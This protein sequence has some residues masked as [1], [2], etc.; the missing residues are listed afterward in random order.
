MT[1]S[2]KNYTIKTDENN[3]EFVKYNIEVKVEDKVSIVKKTY[4]DFKN[5]NES[6]KKIYP[7]SF[8]PD[9][10]C[11]EL[12][13]FSSSQIS[14]ESKIQNLNDYLKKICCVDF[15]DENT[16]KFFNI[17]GAVRD[18]LLR[19]HKNLIE[20]ESIL[21]VSEC[22]QSD[23]VNLSVINFDCNQ[24]S[25][26]NSIRNSDRFCENYVSL[27]ISANINPNNKVEYK[28]KSKTILGKNEVTKTFK[29]FVELHKELKKTLNSDILPSF[30][31]KSFLSQPSQID[32]AGIEKRRKK[33]ERYLAHIFNDPAYHN[34]KNFSWLGIQE[35]FRL[36]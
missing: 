35:N 13:N 22:S 2:I 12:P 3:K 17:Q 7:R 26:R 31:K 11:P 5:L 29:D 10:K 30:P 33:L 4:M 21:Q 20:N 8:Y 18:E 24:E 32:T 19:K 15:Y 28:I 36:I 1:C 27:K 14:T 25:I 23:C 34:E 9:I 6:I 16:L